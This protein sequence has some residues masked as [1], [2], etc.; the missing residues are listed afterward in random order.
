M[1]YNNGLR[2]QEPQVPQDAPGKRIL[3]ATS[4]LLIVFGGFV[5][6]DGVWVFRFFLWNFAQDPL[7][8]SDFLST[9]DILF[10]IFLI[11]FPVL[12]IL[13]GIAGIKNC[14]N[15]E[16]AGK[17]RGLGVACAASELIGTAGALI[18]FG[19]TLDTTV[20]TVLATVVSLA[21]LLAYLS[22]AQKNLAAQREQI[23]TV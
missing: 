7:F 2:P 19:G 22:G 21:L 8:R 18:R 12:H 11:F 4:I 1:T 9:F 5:L 20:A 10:I 15:T 13:A 14:N 23:L 6:I 3:Q 16:K 17:L